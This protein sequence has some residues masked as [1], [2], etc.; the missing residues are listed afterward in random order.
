MKYRFFQ[1][2]EKNKYLPLLG[3]IIT[4]KLSFLKAI[5]I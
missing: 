3:N 4:F 5:F 2:I 1:Y